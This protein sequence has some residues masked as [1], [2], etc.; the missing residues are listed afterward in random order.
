MVRANVLAHEISLQVNGSAG[1]DSRLHFGKNN[2]SKSPGVSSTAEPLIGR[3][4]PWSASQSRRLGSLSP[5][6]EERVQREAHLPGFLGRVRENLD[7]SGQSD[8]AERDGYLGAR[9][10]R[11]FFGE[12]LRLPWQCRAPFFV[13]SLLSLLLGFPIEQI[14]LHQLFAI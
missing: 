11:G 12:P 1:C 2:F 5:V 14:W 3:S 8:P 6:V 9:Q 4:R 10:Q 7:L 13:Q